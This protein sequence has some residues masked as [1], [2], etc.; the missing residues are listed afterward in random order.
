MI[1][2]ELMRTQGIDPDKVVRT[3]GVSDTQ[4]GAMAGNAM[5]Q[6]VLEALFTQIFTAMGTCPTSHA[7]WESSREVLETVHEDPAQHEPDPTTDAAEAAVAEV[8]GT[9][10][11]RVADIFTLSISI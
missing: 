11:V 5:S 6:N 3:L 8:L 2:Q 4:L 10:S 7:P 1:W 9:L